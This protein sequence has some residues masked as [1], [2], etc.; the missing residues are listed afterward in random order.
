MA[1]EYTSVLGLSKWAASDMVKREDFNSDN[2]KIE[3]TY[4]ELVTKMDGAVMTKIHEAEALNVNGK[5]VSFDLSGIDWGAYQYIYID[6]VTHG[7]TSIFTTDVRINGTLDDAYAFGESSYSRAGICEYYTR[8]EFPTGGRIEC[9]THM[10]N[11][12]MGYCNFITYC[13]YERP[14]ICWSKSYTYNDIETISFVCKETSEQYVFEYAK[15]C[16]WGRN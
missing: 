1:S 7:P 8:S 11:M 4:G 2:Q 6:F 13:L 9:N 10:M 14:Q 15:I 16:V 12:G 3:D 5:T